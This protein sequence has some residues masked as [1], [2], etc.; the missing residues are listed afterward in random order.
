MSRRLRHEEE[1]AGAQHH[2]GQYLDAHGNQPR[3][4]RL[5]RSGAT[6]I[7]GTVSNLSVQSRFRS[8]F[9][10]GGT[11]GGCGEAT[12]QFRITQRFNHTQAAD[13]QTCQN[14]PAKT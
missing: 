8:S 6:D 14:R 12:D 9:L 4:I 13:P 11:G 10:E 1:H 5:S 3:G 2:G 7:V